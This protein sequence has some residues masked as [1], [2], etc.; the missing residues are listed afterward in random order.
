MEAWA[1]IIRAAMGTPGGVLSLLVLIL[2][3]VAMRLFPPG[4]TSERG[5]L[6]LF[7]MLLASVGAFTW[8]FYSVRPFVE[9][10][11]RGHPIEAGEELEEE[12]AGESGGGKTRDGLRNRPDRVGRC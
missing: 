3:A 4:R 12:G 10:R 2:G 1:E 9:A 7:A 8:N 11:V 5:R 6:V